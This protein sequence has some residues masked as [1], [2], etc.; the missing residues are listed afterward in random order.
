[1]AETRN[2]LLETRKAMRL[3]FLQESN[4]DKRP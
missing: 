3:V 1:M 4:R 2:L